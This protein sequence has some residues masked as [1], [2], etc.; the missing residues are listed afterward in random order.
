MREIVI[1]TDTTVG[2]DFELKKFY[3]TNK[4][5]T[6]NRD[7]NTEIKAV[8]DIVAP[9]NTVS[10]NDLKTLANT[11]EALTALYYT[12]EDTGAYIKTVQFN[13]YEKYPLTLEAEKSKLY[14]MNT[15]IIY[16]LTLNESMLQRLYGI[17]AFY[18][19]TLGLGLNIRDLEVIYRLFISFYNPFC[20]NTI[21]KV[22]D[23]ENPNVHYL[24]YNNTLQLS[25]YRGT[26]PLTYTTTLNPTDEYTYTPI[27]DI[28]AIEDNIITLTTT[29][30]SQ[31]QPKS[32]INVYNTT[33]VVSPATY[34]SDGT[35]VVKEVHENTITTT[36]NLPSEYNYNPPVVELVAYKNPI[37]NINRTERTIT[38]TNSASNFL[39]G[40]I[41]SIK[42]AVVTTEYETISLDGDYTVSDIV[43]N[44]LYVSET[45]ATDYTGSTGYAYKG[46][47]ACTVHSI[48][49]Q[50]ITIEE[51][52][53]PSMITVNSPIVVHQT[54]GDEDK[55]EYAVVTRISQN[56]ITFSGN[57]TSMTAST[58]I[59]RKPNPLP[60]VLVEVSDSASNA[61]PNGEFIVDNPQQAISYLG[62]Q[63][64]LVLPSNDE[65]SESSNNTGNFRNCG[66]Q[67]K[68]YYIINM[69]ST[70]ITKM[71]L[72]GLYS[73]IYEGAI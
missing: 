53:V 11:I 5:T 29:V 22:Q 51:S 25:N 31:V 32:R 65:P 43:G 7:T 47:K 3:V 63:E 57:I 45:P 73:D 4:G 62:L 21:E 58:G 26:S 64:N 10:L 23:E 55:K 54:I 46:I 59:L 6:T 24:M 15:H 37:T 38:L 36:E 14:I 67:I 41:I 44:T 72:K 49:G 66:K 20:Y 27:A 52:S 61:L 50:V 39:I 56:K 34:S 28:T 68:E 33:T 17:Q 42:D 12:W 71:N 19:D 69:L 35:Y 1:D 70:G 18:K 9:N 13:N 8:L 16:D 60:L 48:A 30:P 40:D 2:Y